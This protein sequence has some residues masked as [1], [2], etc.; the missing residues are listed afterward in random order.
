MKTTFYPPKLKS[1]YYVKHPGVEE[2][3][4]IKE[5]GY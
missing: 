4:I 1:R 2:R 5:L 3:M